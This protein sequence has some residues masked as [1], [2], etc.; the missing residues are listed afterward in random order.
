ME[1]DER[2]VLRY[3]GYKN[4]PPDAAVLGQIETCKQ[5][6]R[7]VRPKSV[8]TEYEVKIGEDTVAFE[9]LMIS[10]KAIAAHLLGCEKVIVYAATLGAE[11]DRL[12]TR[13][14]A[15]D[16]SLGVVLQACMAA[17]LEGFCDAEQEELADRAEKQGYYLKP[18][19]SPGYG[20][21]PIEYQKNLLDM[22]QATKKIGIALTDSF[23]LTPTKS[24][25]ALIGMTK[26][27]TGCSIA[28]CKLCPNV[29]C[30]FRKE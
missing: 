29:D 17:L 12:L 21:F 25:T 26:D 15:I 27:K 11:S 19:Y 3:L 5:L 7:S 18:R 8:W 10:S 24:I 14:S 28:K 2:E 4:S 23:M 6:L 22:L 20:D 9:G 13:H 1:L 30:P 16:M